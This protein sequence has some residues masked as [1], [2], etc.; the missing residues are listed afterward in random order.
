MWNNKNVNIVF[1][2]FQKDNFLFL[3]KYGKR[4][5]KEICQM[6]I[7]DQLNILYIIN[8]CS[9][10]HI[11]ITAE[12]SLS[13]SPNVVWESRDQVKWFDWTLAGW[14]GKN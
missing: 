1:F 10:Y 8:A 9:F 2:S 12:I 4:F 5:A 13:L 7:E 6:E 3:L 11:I 14:F